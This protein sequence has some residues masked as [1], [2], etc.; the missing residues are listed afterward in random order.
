MDRAKPSQPE[1]H[2]GVGSPSPFGVR[3]ER[4]KDGGELMEWQTE[5]GAGTEVT[6][7]ELRVVDP[8]HN[9]TGKA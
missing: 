3:G 1:D 9:H 8:L 5:P 6:G 4:G 7:T 2:P